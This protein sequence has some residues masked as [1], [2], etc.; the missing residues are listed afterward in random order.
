MT[1]ISYP[2]ERSM[3]KTFLNSVFIVHCLYTLLHISAGLA[4]HYVAVEGVSDYAFALSL[5]YL[6]GA[7]LASDGKTLLSKKEID[8]KKLK[9][10]LDSIVTVNIVAA[11]PSGIEGLLIGRW[12]WDDKFTQSFVSSKGAMGLLALVVFYTVLLAYSLV[13]VFLVIRQNQDSFT[14]A[15]SELSSRRDN[16]GDLAVSN[17]PLSVVRTVVTNDQLKSQRGGYQAAP[18]SSSRPE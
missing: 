13:L 15:V 3:I 17:P 4:W 14:S 12:I 7:C 16:L 1:Q 11:I 2:L 8:P 6:V 18:D 5:V 9:R 10:S